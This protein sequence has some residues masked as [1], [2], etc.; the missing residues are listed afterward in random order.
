MYKIT[1]F[2]GDG[3]GPEVT[4][5]ALKILKKTAS[6]FHLVFEFKEALLGGASIDQYGVPMSDEARKLALEADAVFL[7]AVGGPKWDALEASKRPEKALLELRKMLGVFT[8]LRPV[9]LFKGLEDN[10][11][12]KREVIEGIDFLILRELTGGIYFGS[13]RGIEPLAGGGEKGFNTE[14]Y[15]TPEIERIA[16][17]AFE[18]ARRRRKKVTSVDKANV[19]ESSQLWRKTVNRVHQDYP[20]VALDHRY[21]DDCAMQFIRNPKQFDV[22]VTSNL[23]GDI[24]SDEAAMLTGS[25]GMLA[26]ASVGADIALYEPVHGS[27]PDIAGKNRANPLAA[28][29]SVAMMLE[30]SFNLPDLARMIEK[31]V[32]AVLNEG[33]RTADL[34]VAGTT[35]LSCTEMGDRVAEKIKKI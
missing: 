2:P 3:I 29:L 25:I 12:L 11:T 21:V 35:Q 28:I 16:V 24:L 30:F 9:K 7:G 20:D 1:V 33:F 13:P 8:N 32:Q 26:S 31:S 23:F 22:V 27:A 17:K 18:F 15:T 34:Y 14:V 5:E 4:A 6:V 10:S 19:L